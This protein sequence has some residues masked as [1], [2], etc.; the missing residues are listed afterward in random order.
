MSAKASNISDDVTIRWALPSDLEALE[1]VAA[2]DSRKLPAGPL[3]VAA[4]D[5]QIWA[6]LSVLDGVAIADPF[7][8]SGDLVGLLRTR[9][10]Q[11]RDLRPRM[12]VLRLEPLLAR[13]R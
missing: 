6:G 12:P 11:L 4:V 9:A 2:L 3:L 8:P 5:G 7:V 1:R 13:L 10:S